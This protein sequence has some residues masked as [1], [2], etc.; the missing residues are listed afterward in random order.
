MATGKDTQSAN[1]SRILQRNL[2]SELLDI[3]RGTGELASGLGQKLYLVGGLVRDLLLGRPSLD[4]DLVVEGEAL[5]LAEGLAARYPGS[6]VAHRRFGTAKLRY[7]K[8]SIDLAT[9]RSESYFRPGALPAVRPGVIR[10]DLFRRDF[11][12]NA[13]AVH[14]DPAYYGDLLD[15]YDGKQDLELGLIRIL[16]QRSFVDDATR[17]FRAL[18]Y[19]QRLGFHLE[20]LTEAMLRQTVTM[21]D[22]I[23]ADRIRHELELILKEERP[24]LV[25]RRAGELGLLRALN[26]GLGDDGWLAETFAQARQR[27][28]PASP[29]VS[30]YLALLVYRLTEADAERFM[31][32]IN[33]TAKLAHVFRETM[34]LK[35]QQGSLEAKKVAPSAVFHLLEGHSLEAVQANALATSSER[36][37]EWLELFLSRLRHIRPN[38]D[39]DALLALGVKAGPEMGQILQALRDARLDGR[40]EDEQQEKALVK[41]WLSGRMFDEQSI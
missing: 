35:G 36:V 8:W 34:R 21:V 33:P 24:E 29:S 5:K 39:G 30:L 4:L 31:Q 19:E 12:I 15:P 16:H 27:C 40:V 25:L 6:W 23:G 38:L 17:M 13:M 22:T 28:H 1:L 20:Q 3:L 10:E 26:S 7:G 14:L 2:P 41:E 37:K 11:T 9:A 32:R 18:R